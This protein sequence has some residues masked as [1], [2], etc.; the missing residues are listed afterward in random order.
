MKS[1]NEE[2]IR[3]QLTFFDY[4]YPSISR[5]IDDLKNESKSH[6]LQIYDLK[7][8]IKFQNENINQY[9]KRFSA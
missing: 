5:S 8:Q 4:I 3:Q 1:T 9:K 7:N 6:A 2:K